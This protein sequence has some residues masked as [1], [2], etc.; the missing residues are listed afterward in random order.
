M[1]GEY[2]NLD[3]IICFHEK[4]LMRIVNFMMPLLV[5]MA[6]AGQAHSAFMDNGDGTVT[7]TVTGLMWD[8]CTAGQIFNPGGS[9]DVKCAGSG[10]PPVYQARE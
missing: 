2:W 9:N 3:P 8:Q 5:W 1:S 6:V 10:A 4:Q 7:D